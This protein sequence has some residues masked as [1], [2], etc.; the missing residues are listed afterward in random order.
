VIP[1]SFRDGKSESDL[2][3]IPQESRDA[4]EK[5]HARL[6]RCT[7]VLLAMFSQLRA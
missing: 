2:K 6:Q 3:S 5:P 7:D 4:K 1:V